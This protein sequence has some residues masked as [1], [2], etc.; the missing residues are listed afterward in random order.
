MVGGLDRAGA[1]GVV[2]S[3]PAVFGVERVAQGVVGVPP[4]GW[5]DVERFAG[6]QVHP[7]HQN[8]HMAAA[9]GFPVQYG[10][11]GVAVGFEAGERQPFKGP[12]NFVDLVVAGCVF[13]GPGDD[14]GGV[15]MDEFQ[16]VC[17]IGYQSG[18]A[19]QHPDLGPLL[20]GVVGVLEDVFDGG[21]GRSC[22]PGDEF[23]VHRHRLRSLTPWPTAGA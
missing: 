13:R 14:C 23:N 15:P 4:A 10:G 3:G 17:D 2:R 7:G 1:G 18:V 6:F 16:R 19:T 11:P 8:V 21:L 22:A 9:T 20:A 5:G 12:Q